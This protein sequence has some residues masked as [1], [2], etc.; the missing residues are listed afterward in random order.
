MWS[1]LQKLHL[2]APVCGWKFL[3]EKIKSMPPWL[4]FISLLG[5]LRFSVN[6]KVATRKMQEGVGVL[7]VCRIDTA[8][9]TIIRVKIACKANNK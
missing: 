4:F 6:C 2:F 8:R 7:V 5:V 1:Q 9:E 3:S